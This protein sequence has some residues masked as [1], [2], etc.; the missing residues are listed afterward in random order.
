[1]KCTFT[2]NGK[3]TT[4]EAGETTSLVRV[5]RDACGLVETREGCGEGQ[6]G[7]CLVFVDGN[8]VNSCL[9]PLFRVQGA[10]VDTI[11]GLRDRRLFTELQAAFDAK[12]VFECGFCSGGVLMAAYSL[13]LHARAPSDEAIRDALSGNRCK[14][15]TYPAI[16]EAVQS[17]VATRRRRAR[18]RG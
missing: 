6:C 5:L 4:V 10:E 17:V 14:C 15:G 3:E 9:I 7:A 11:E 13:L 18:R 8:L 1:M 12:R 16:F 2:L